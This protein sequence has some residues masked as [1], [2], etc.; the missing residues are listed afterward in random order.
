MY[1]RLFTASTSGVTYTGGAAR[2]VWE[3]G[4]TANQVLA[5]HSVFIGNYGTAEYGDAKAQGMFVRFI[6]AYSTFTSGSGGTTPTAEPHDGGAAFT[7]T[8]EANN[9]TIAVVNTGTFK[10]LLN[11][12]FNTQAGFFYKPT[13]EERIIIHPSQTFIVTFPDDGTLN[14][15]GDISKLTSNIIFEVIGAA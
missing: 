12:S 11:E 14:P 2:D 6:R 15:S 10:T 3:L 5:I 13:P 9:S 7:G 1:G 8:V 4:A